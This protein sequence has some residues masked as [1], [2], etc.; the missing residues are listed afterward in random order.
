MT[1]T[2][3]QRQSSRKATRH[4]RP[5]SVDDIDEIHAS[6]KEVER[7][8]SV[9]RSIDTTGFE[10]LSIFVPTLSHRESQ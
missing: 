7:T 2:S 1:H 6:Q 4:E 9:I 3:K 10:P 8:Y 5:D